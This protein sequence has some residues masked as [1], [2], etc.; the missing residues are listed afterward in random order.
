MILMTIFWIGAT[1]FQKWG[2]LG[3]LLLTAL[4][5]SVFY[6]ATGME[7]KRLLD[8]LMLYIPYEG[9]VLPVPVN[10]LFSFAILYYYRRME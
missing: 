9:K 4:T 10:T 2:A 7:Y 5:V 8:I 3:F 1:L 6:F